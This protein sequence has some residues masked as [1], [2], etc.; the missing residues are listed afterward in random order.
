MHGYLKA[1]TTLDED[2]GVLGNL[3]TKV[4]IAHEWYGVEFVWKWRLV[5]DVDVELQGRVVEGGQA[6]VHTTGEG[7]WKRKEEGLML[8]SK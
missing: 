3:H 5:T 4:T 6:F 2:I 8:E 7:V 1:P